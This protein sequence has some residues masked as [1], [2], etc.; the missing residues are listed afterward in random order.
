MLRAPEGSPAAE[1]VRSARST[2]VKLDE[3]R[4]SK[5]RHKLLVL[6]FF[7]MEINVNNSQL[8]FRQSDSKF[9]PGSRVSRGGPPP[10]PVLDPLEAPGCVVFVEECSF[11][12]PHPTQAHS[13]WYFPRHRCTIN[14]NCKSNKYMKLIG[15]ARSS[16]CLAKSGAPNFAWLR[17]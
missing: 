16:R 1:V 2:H 7:V 12:H 8:R 13:P 14:E 3:R 4:K 9:R 5:M 17:G 11:L 10:P 15:V 6:D